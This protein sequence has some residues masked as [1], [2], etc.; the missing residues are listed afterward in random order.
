M[1]NLVQKI[2]VYLLVASLI[3]CGYVNR[4]EVIKPK[5]YAYLA[6]FINKDIRWGGDDWYTFVSHLNDKHLSEL[7]LEWGILKESSPGINTTWIGTQKFLTVATPKIALNS[8]G[9]RQNTITLLQKTINGA[10]YFTGNLLEKGVQWHG[11]VVWADKKNDVEQAL[12]DNSSFGAERALISTIFEKNWDELN[13]DQRKAV[14][15]KSDLRN[16]PAKDKAAMIAATGAA[17]LATLN[18]TVVLTGFAFYT[19]MSSVIAATASVVGVTLPFA[20]YTG[21]STII[22]TLTGPVGWSILAAASVGVG[23][24]ELS[25]DASKVTRMVISLH[26]L[27]AKVLDE[28]SVQG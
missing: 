10:R 24:Y 3:S 27:K 16:L 23:L 19:T 2:I 25:P 6:P 26:I 4:P 1:K 17:A 18:A 9:G 5:E 20:V 12:Y 22:G 7:S 11:I 13:T 14:I 21:A 28:S 8:L 15:E